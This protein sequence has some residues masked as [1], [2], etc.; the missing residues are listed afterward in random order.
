[1]TQIEVVILRSFIH[2]ALV[3]TMNWYQADGK[4]SLEDIADQVFSAF[5]VSKA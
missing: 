3:D 2:G 1:M 4:Y 5:F